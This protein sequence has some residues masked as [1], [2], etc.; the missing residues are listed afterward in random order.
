MALDPDHLRRVLGL[1]LRN[2]RHEKELGLKDLAARSGLSVS[3]L[4]EIEKG[5]KFPKP[6]KLLQ[7]AQGL[8]VPYEA[9]VSTQ[10]EGELAPMQDLLESPFLR[11]FPF[12]QYGINSEAI[13]GLVADVS[14]R[15]KR[16]EALVHTA[17]EIGRVYQM[18]V[19]HFLL[20]ALRSYQRLHGN[21][22]D[23]IEVAARQFRE[24][25]GWEDDHVPTYDELADCLRGQH[26]YVVDTEAL[27]ASEHLSGTRAV[28]V[29]GWPPRLLL[30]D[31]LLSSQKAFMVGR[32]IGYQRLELTERSMIS[33]PLRV[34]SYDQ[35]IDDF[36]AA[37]FSGAVMIPEDALR[38]DLETLFAQPKWSET[39]FLGLLERYQVTP[40]T[41]FYRLSQVLPTHFGLRELFFLRFSYEPEGKGFRLTKVLNM[42]SLK[43]PIGAQQREHFCRRLPGL[44]LL[45]GAMPEGE[46]PV[47]PRVAVQ[48]SKFL[49]DGDEYL[50]ISVSRPLS[51]T[52][53]SHTSISLGWKLD[54]R[55]KRRVAFVNDEAIERCDVHLSCER[56]PLAAE[57]CDERGAPPRLLEA[58][59][60]RRAMR[61]ELAG[62]SGN[63][64]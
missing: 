23:D 10:L 43:F 42:S 24:E 57:Q 2:F 56:C 5:K 44:R 27:Q 21:R 49:Q 38:G 1:K 51:L 22:F 12:Q 52:D 55:A 64:G 18:E 46:S 3:Y 28:T 60:R 48:R 63:H 30:N 31:R 33:P 20:A 47:P 6:D 40:E 54:A 45:K 13:F 53:D 8:E 25:Q 15:G 11:E 14:S 29:E 37:Y 59:R 62:L 35:V 41:F 32:E 61:E 50:V 17:L 4:S 19:E 36:M 16:S 39:D 7:L 26:G 34:T 9:L 58:S